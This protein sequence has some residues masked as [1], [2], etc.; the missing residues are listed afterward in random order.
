VDPTGKKLNDI[1]A[2]EAAIIEFKTTFKKQGT[3]PS[4]GI[5]N[6]AQMKG[7]NDFSQDVSSAI[8]VGP[9]PFALVLPFFSNTQKVNTW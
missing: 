8:C 5:I 6:P 1:Q 7:N 2:Q 9:P 4:L 3:G